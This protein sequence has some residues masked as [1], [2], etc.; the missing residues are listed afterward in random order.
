MTFIL[1][2]INFLVSLYV[3]R[4]KVRNPATAWAWLM[5]MIAIPFFG[6]LVY[7][8]IGQDSRKIKIFHEKYLTDNEL[9]EEFNE[10]FCENYVFDDSCDD[11]T[12]N[13]IELNNKTTMSN[14]T[15]NNELYTYLDGSEKFRELMLCIDGAKTYIHLE[16]YI[17]RD[18]K[19]GNFLLNK[20]I[21][22]AKEGVE[23]K[24]LVD[25]LGTFK[26]TPMFFEPL[27]HAGCEVAVFGP[28][29]ASRLNY[30]NHRKLSVIDGKCGFIGGFNIGD[31]YIYS[32]KLGTWRD[33]HIKIYGDAVKSLEL[34][35]IKDWNF[36][37]TSKIEITD[38]YFPK[39]ET[40]R[41]IVPIQILSSGPD[42]KVSS[43]HH[44]FMYM[45]AKARK[46]I[47]ITTPYFMPDENI[48]LALKIASLSGI[49]VKII[50]P[51]IGDHPFVLGGNLSYCSTLLSSN[52][53]CYMY[54]P[55]GGT[56]FIHSKQI[57]VDDLYINLGSTNFDY[58]SL[59]LNFEVNALIIESELAKSFKKQFLIDLENSEEIT[60]E[61]FEKLSPLDN[62]KLT[63]GKLISPL[64]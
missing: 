5:F 61:Y 20:L 13:F 6:M 26:K 2:F 12:K 24:V 28:L 63:V 38:K 55:S 42:T 8:L 53:R 46:Y 56:A 23:V 59:H 64:L 60:K 31:E 27:K 19:L 18:D 32:R 33:T 16:Y 7:F 22:K 29:H 58:R 15:Y 10:R 43:I 47:Y 39:M 21:Q 37:A 30:R 41:G 40:I 62:L 44:S 36:C 50:I 3:I 1:L 48:L 49:D 52:I 4:I 25:A 45:I 17:L 34:Q 11:V 14:I 57:V 9:K 51:S 54:K 35:F